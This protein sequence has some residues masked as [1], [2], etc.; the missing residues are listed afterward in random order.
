MPEAEAEAANPQP[1]PR[2]QPPQDTI[3]SE[4]LLKDIHRHRR[5]MATKLAE[6]SKLT[7]GDAMQ[8]ANDTL[9]PLI[10]DVLSLVMMLEEQSDWAAAEIEGLRGDRSQLVKEDAERFGRFLY[11]VISMSELVREKLVKER[12]AGDSMETSLLERLDAMSSEAVSLIDL[13]KEVEMDDASADDTTE[14]TADA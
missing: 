11:E 12:A 5:R 10:G 8:E 13:V 2:Q 6:R 3:D 9:L 4:D 14:Q 1:S 7:P